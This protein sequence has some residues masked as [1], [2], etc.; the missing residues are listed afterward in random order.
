MCVELLELSFID[1]QLQ[2]P[3]RLESAGLRQSRIQPLV[4]GSKFRAESLQLAARSHLVEF[5][6]KPESARE[7]PIV[8]TMGIIEKTVQLDFASRHPECFGNFGNA[9][10]IFGLSQSVE[11]ASLLVTDLDRL[12]LCNP[13][14][15]ESEELL[16]LNSNESVFMTMN[17]LRWLAK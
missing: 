7:S 10:G 13:D 15:G 1:I 14:F 4:G 6:K 2:A 12:L 3:P 16:R 9:A 5:Q 17:V 11:D 8:E